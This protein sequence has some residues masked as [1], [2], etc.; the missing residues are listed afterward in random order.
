VLYPNV[1]T[2]TLEKDQSYWMLHDAAPESWSGGRLEISYE[3]NTWS[4]FA[5]YSSNWNL[6][7]PFQFTPTYPTRK[8]KVRVTVNTSPGFTNV[9]DE[10]DSFFTVAGM[11]VLLVFT[12]QHWQAEN[13][14][15]IVLWCAVIEVLI[16]I[17]II[18]LTLAR[19]G[20]LSMVTLFF[21]IQVLQKWP[22]TLD[23]SV[24]FA[25]TSLTAI[26]VL[27]AITTLA[28]RFSLARAPG[29]MLSV[30]G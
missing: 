26:L 17:S 29:S 2:D 6:G 15:G 5:D 7:A 16:V 9:Y 14:A 21:F 27:A 10:S 12:D 30:S 22:L 20:L 8:A 23:A 24:W 25:G 11:L 18:V 19:F 13:L 3:T 1:K 4:L 28:M